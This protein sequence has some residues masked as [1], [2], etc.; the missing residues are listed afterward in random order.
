[1][2][3]SIIL[4]LSAFLLIIPYN[5]ASAQVTS[6][7]VLNT[8]SSDEI[9]DY[10]KDESTVSPLVAGS[11]VTKILQK[12]ALPLLKVI[13][14]S[15]TF[16]D[17]K[18]D[19]W[20]LGR[21]QYYVEYGSLKFGGSNGTHA[22]KDLI[23]TGRDTIRFS[24][25]SQDLF[26]K[27]PVAVGIFTT[28][29]RDPLDSKGLK[30][31][32]Y[33]DYTF[34]G[35]YDTQY[36]NYYVG[37]SVGDDGK[38][39]PNMFY[40]IVDAPCTQAP[41]PLP[42]S[43]SPEQLSLNNVENTSNA[44]LYNDRYVYLNNDKSV[45][46][47]S[48]NLSDVSESLTVNELYGEFYDSST[49][50]LTDQTKSL[51]PNTTVRV[52]DVITDITYNVENDYTEIKFASNYSNIEYHSAYFKG[53]LTSE[54]SIGDTLALK[55]KLITIAEINGQVFVDLDYNYDKNSDYPTIEEFLD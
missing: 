12:L 40:T 35:G 55:F 48:Y 27:S 20:D 53:N 51:S 5:N 25:K 2:K 31:G 17:T 50:T 22:Y 10:S 29:Q 49:N 11:I 15:I 9:Q 34:P 28:S 45:K 6:N 44:I 47:A 21:G 37:L 42:T 46:A 36:S 16:P 26:Q 14:G 19:I 52:K 1:M 4:F 3:K 33:I 7:I 13:G 43:I 23:V 24:V 41:C 30:S 32:Q 8:D 38:W 39:A 18:G 54:Y